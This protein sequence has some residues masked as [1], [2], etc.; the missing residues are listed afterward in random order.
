MGTPV[1]RQIKIYSPLVKDIRVSIYNVIIACN[2]LLLYVLHVSLLSL[3]YTYRYSRRRSS[4]RAGSACGGTRS[5]TCRSRTPSSSPSTR[6]CSEGYYLWVCLVYS[7][8]AWGDRRLYFAWDCNIVKI[9]N[10]FFDVSK[11]VNITRNHF[12]KLVII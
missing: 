12:I 8:D 10:R 7:S 2:A 9:F 5:T 4:T 11:S 3:M 6:L 1:R